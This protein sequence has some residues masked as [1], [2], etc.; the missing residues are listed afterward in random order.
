MADN[1]SCTMGEIQMV[2]GM[3]ITIPR[4]DR[5][6]LLSMVN[7]FRAVRVPP[8]NKP[9]KIESSRLKLTT[10]KLDYNSVSFQS[11]FRHLKSSYK[12]TPCFYY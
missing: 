11:N 2:K 6:P 12:H 4:S 3:D 8:R 5:I 9:C 1:H 7:R 10:R